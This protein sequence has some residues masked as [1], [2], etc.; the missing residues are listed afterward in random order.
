[1]FMGIDQ[2]GNTYHDLKHPRRDL[3][4]ILSATR[5]RKIYETNPD[6]DRH[7]G[8]VIRGLWIRLFKVEQ[9]FGRS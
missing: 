7:I 9:W 1:M 2:Y 6:G 5:A 8:Y 4:E 3:L